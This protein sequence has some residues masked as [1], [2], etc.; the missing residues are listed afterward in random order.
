MSDT[1]PQAEILA[2]MAEDWFTFG[3]STEG[4]LF[5]LPNDGSGGRVAMP[6][7]GVRSLR[8]ELAAGYLKRFGRPPSSNALGDMLGAIEGKCSSTEPAPL[9]LR[10][11]ERD[12]TVWLDLGRRDGLAVRINAKGWTTTTDYPVIFRRTALTGELPEPVLGG[13]L[14]ELRELINVT[15]EAW[16]LLVAW[17]LSTLFPSVP[18]PILGL[19]GEQGTGKTFA[20]RLL[21]STVDPSPAPLRT[22]PRDLAEWG[23]AASGSWLVGLDNL[24]SLPDWLSDALCRA[25]TGDGIVRRR[26]YSDSDL[27]VLAFRRCIVMTSIDPGALAGDVADRLLAIELERIPDTQRKLDAALARAWSA[28][29]PNVLGGLLDLAVKVREVLPTVALER[30]PRMADF[31]LV[32][33]AVDQVL[34]TK[35]LASY[36]NQR[37]VLAADV[38]ES[39]PVAATVRDFM[40]KRKGEAFVGSAGTLLGRLAPEH[41]GRRWPTTPKALS[42]R[43]TRVAPALRA[44]GIE[45]EP[46]PRGHGGVRLWRLAPVVADEPDQEADEPDQ[47]SGER[48][49]TTV[50][51]VT[52]SALTSGNTGDGCGDGSNGPSSTVTTTVTTPTTMLTSGNTT[53]GDGG[54]GGDG[55]FGPDLISARGADCPRCGFGWSSIGH[56]ANCGGPDR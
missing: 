34:D 31:A 26:L 28:V 16:P 14:N 30:L 43:L 44:V 46:Q 51:T 2:A 11:A 15:A 10:I 48:T 37:T 33:A 54:D 47:E 18:H 23:T 42:G 8:A 56:A 53:S 45:V 20:A 7:R 9:Y 35:G 21:V 4:D 19:L 39:D 32:L 52:K 12:G 49:V 6:L 13:D 5:A 25:V 24:S 1:P 22:Q 38:V 41:P 3:Q 36:L 40:I 29:H 50:T 27:S 17:E 55:S